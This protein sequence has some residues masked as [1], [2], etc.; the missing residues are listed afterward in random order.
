MKALTSQLKDPILS[1]AQQK[2]DSGKWEKAMRDI[3]YF[4]EHYVPKRLF[5]IKLASAQQLEL[6][7]AVQDGRKYFLIR[8]PRKG[9][10]TILVAIIAT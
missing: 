4:V 2:R 7:Q 3:F 10:K 8:A 5:D 9:G 6:L 1:L